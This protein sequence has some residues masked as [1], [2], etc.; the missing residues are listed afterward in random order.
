[1]FIQ[2]NSVSECMFNPSTNMPILMTECIIPSSVTSRTTSTQP[3]MGWT[4]QNSGST[5]PQKRIQQWEKS[6]TSLT[7]HFRPY[8]NEEEDSKRPQFLLWLHQEEWQKQIL[9]NYGNTLT[10]ID[11]TYK[12]TSPYFFLSVRT[13]VGYCAA[14][15]FVVQ[16]DSA[17]NISEALLYLKQSNPSWS[18]PY[19]LCNYSEAEISAIHKLSLETK[20]YLCDFHRE[21]AWT[22]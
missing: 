8:V 18:P 19:F 7:Q 10:L 17:E 4:F 11:A 15:E 6:S 3:K 22:W 21:Q 1:M 13:N 2:C 5:N 12:T 20:I 14:A 16:S 9:A